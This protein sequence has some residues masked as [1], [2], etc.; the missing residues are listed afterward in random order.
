MKYPDTGYRILSLFRYWNTINYFFPYK[1]LIEKPWENT[2]Q[3]FI[4]KLITVKNKEEYFKSILLLICEIKDSHAI[5]WDS[6]NT[7]NRLFGERIIPI[8]ISNIEDKPVVT[9]FYTQGNY[10]KNNFQ[11]GDILL[12]LDNKKVTNLSKKIAP[13]FSTILR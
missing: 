3:E 4:P 2:L 8:I 10:L 13:N 12:K 6:E 9:G 11:K 5:I 1:K 7:S